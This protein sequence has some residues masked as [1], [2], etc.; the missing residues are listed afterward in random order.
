MTVKVT[1]AAHVLAQLKAL[2][3][4]GNPVV[5]ERAIREGAQ[6]IIDAAKQN[7]PTPEVAAD[8][9]VVN[10]RASGGTVT[11]DVGLPGGPRPSFVGL[12][13]ERGTGPR[14]QETTG[15]RTGAMAARPWLRPAF[16]ANSARA[17]DAVGAVIKARIDAVAKNSNG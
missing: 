7:A 14:V 8:V 5:L 16:D 13:F 6:P 10:L 9:D 15:R 3:A 2:A 17:V 12:F 4:V 1:G 11:A